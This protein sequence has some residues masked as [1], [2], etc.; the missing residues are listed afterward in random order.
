MDKEWIKFSFCVKNQSH[1]T[2][3]LG[4]VRPSVDDDDDD[5][6]DAG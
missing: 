5:D 1:Q 6:D 3:T 2:T 4:S